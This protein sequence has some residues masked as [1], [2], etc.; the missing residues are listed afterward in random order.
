[1]FIGVDSEWILGSP[2]RLIALVM[3]GMTGPVTVNGI[4][5]TA[6]TAP[7]VQPLMP[8]LRINPI[9]NDEQI[10]AI[11]TYVRNT[12]GN[13][14]RPVMPATVQRVSETIAARGMFYMVDQLMKE[15]PFEDGEKAQNANP[16]KETR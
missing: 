3:D 16:P 1:M 13:N 7:Q 11:L 9:I 4:T 6:D 5:Y 10:A 15:Q 12:F 2:D 14:A 8:G